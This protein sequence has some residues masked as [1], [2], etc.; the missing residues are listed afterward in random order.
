MESQ[1]SVGNYLGMLAFTGRILGPSRKSAADL[2]SPTT[3]LFLVRLN[4]DSSECL[5]INNLSRPK[6]EFFAICLT[7]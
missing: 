5:N 3:W 6:M 4:Y 1:L 2:S 7:S